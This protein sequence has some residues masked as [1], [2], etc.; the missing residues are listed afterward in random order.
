MKKTLVAISALALFIQAFAEDVFDPGAWNLKFYSGLEAAGSSAVNPTGFRG[1]KPSID[2][3]WESGMAK[4]GVAK[5]VDTK[6][7]GVVDWSISAYVRCGQDGRASVSMEF[8]DAKGK[9]LGVQNGIFRTFA[10]WTKV[11]WKFTSP[12]KAVGAEVHL[13]SL[14][15]APVSFASVSVASSQGIDKNE[16]PFDMKILPAEWNRD[17][18]GGKTRM[19]NFTDAPIAMTVL[20]KGEKSELKAPSFEI[21]LPECLELKDAFCAFNGTYGG[22]KPVSS[23]P[24][25]VGGRRINRV[26]FE[27][28]RYLPRL[29]GKFDTDKGG[30]ITLVVGPKTD[31]ASGIYPIVCRIADGE[32]LAAE[33]IVDMEFR[34]M[35]KGLRISKNFTVMG[36]NNADRRFADD[37]ALVAAL[38]AYEA[39]GIRFVRLDRCGLDPFPRVG[40]IRNIL[41]KRPVSYIHAARLGDLWMMSR[42]GLNKKSLKAMGGRLSVTSDKA[43][44]R[45]NKICP[46]FFSH[47]ERFY[48]HLEESV[49][50]QILTTSGV[51]DG[52]WVTMDMEPWQSGTY[53]YCTNC[54]TAFGKFAKLDRVPTMAEA[55][56]MKDEWA[57]FRVRHSARAVEMVREILHRINPTLKLMDY[58]YI[59][60]Y[61]NPESRAKFIRNCAK[62]T[63]L[64][65]RWLDGHLCSYYHRIGK[66][67]FEA[68]KNNVRALKKAYY[69]MA[70]LSGFA[71]WVRPGEVL[72]PRQVR[73]FALAAFVNGCP[74]YAFY[75]GN[76]FDGEMLI[77]MM[78]A[79]DIVARYEDLAWGKADGK[80]VVE[81]PSE[82]MAYASVVRKDGSE[83]VAVFNYDGDEPIEVRVAGKP[84]TVEP[85]DVKF[86]E[87]QK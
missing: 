18:N 64:N 56:T 50:P 79:Q 12:K 76:C 87:I 53:C 3:K 6:L 77:A 59:L 75:S 40:E 83:V 44:R 62:D 65:E 5:R 26:R 23:T 68:M 85:F 25:E 52:D 38:K 73:Q 58:D 57:E 82:Q 19:L 32:R 78:E 67:A 29:T 81:G 51:K 43:G 86:I 8:F 33:R 30:G 71:S 49:I 45:A 16:V 41:E 14:A 35:P 72:N 66:L 47:N 7:K 60:E 13:L 46:Q 24:V 2:L 1:D 36:W 80:T 37:N 4:F 69:P 70:G 22:E 55:L 84:H 10:K 11:D 9:S 74:G 27:K 63:L 28:M 61:G 54:L 15:E 39:A 48:R 17:W 21:D 34:P 42:V 20:L 31:I